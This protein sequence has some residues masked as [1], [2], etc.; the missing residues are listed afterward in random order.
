MHDVQAGQPKK[1]T[2][3]SDSQSPPS[4]ERSDRSGLLFYSGGE[5]SM[6]PNG[7]THRTFWRIKLTL[8][9]IVSLCAAGLPSVYAGGSH[10][11][12]ALGT[13]N[14]L[15]KDNKGNPLAG[16]VIALLKE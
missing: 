8:L 1:T 3:D 5:I 16:V 6:M 11:S 15:V 9:A 13:V 2:D 10:G 7:I 12:P 14:G 4:R